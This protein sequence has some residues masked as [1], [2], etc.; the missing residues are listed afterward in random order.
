MKK[1]T[2]SRAVDLFSAVPKAGSECAEYLFRDLSG[3]ETEYNRIMEMYEQGARDLCYLF[4]LN[5][6][7]D[8]GVFQHLP[9]FCQHYGIKCYQVLA[10]PK[11]LQKEVFP[12][13]IGV[14]KEDPRAKTISDI[15]EKNSQPKQESF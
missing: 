2:L 8:P 10:K 9:L 13:L 12:F 6:F 4:M 15:L 3:Y 1:K 14:R 11:A 7:V 5:G